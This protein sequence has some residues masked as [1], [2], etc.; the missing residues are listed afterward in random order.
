MVVASTR[1]GNLAWTDPRGNLQLVLREDAI[2][3]AGPEQTYGSRLE[4]ATGQELSRFP[5]R[6]ACTRTTGCA[7]SIF[8]RATGGT[9]RVIT[10]SN[11]AQRLAPMRPPCQDG[12]VISNGMLYW[13]P[14]MCS[15]CQ[16]SLYGHIGLAP[17]SAPSHDEADAELYREA[18]HIYQTTTEVQ[19][20][21]SQ[22]GDWTTYRADN[23]RSDQVQTPV[24]DRVKLQWSAENVATDLPTAPVVAGG[25]VFVADRTGIVRA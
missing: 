18:L 19:P 7:D 9:V 4:Y 11:T 14:W 2:Y 24:P 22:P 10:D 8:F 3:A 17:S 16:L 20:L 6:R 25:L 12:V 15:G 1:D 23:R 13:G 21:D 5:A